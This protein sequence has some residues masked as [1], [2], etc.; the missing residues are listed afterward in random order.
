MLLASSWPWSSA[1]SRSSSTS[2][3][4]SGPSWRRCCP[5]PSCSSIPRRRPRRRCWRWRCPPSCRCSSATCSSPASS[6][7]SRELHPVTILVALIFWGMLWG[8]AGM[9]LA[10]P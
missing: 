5:C 7:E 2:S 1:C 8:V 4:A 9:I 10:A 3:P 6:A